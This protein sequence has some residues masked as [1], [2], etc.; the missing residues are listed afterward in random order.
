MVH[1]EMASGPRGAAGEH[2]LRLLDAPGWLAEISDEELLQ[3]PLQIVDG[4][5]VVSER[6]HS[7]GEYAD[8]SV[9]VALDDNVGLSD[10]VGPAAIAVLMGLRGGRTPADALPGLAAA[11]ESIPPDPQELVADMARALVSRGLLV[12]TEEPRT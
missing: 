8:D 1:H 12:R 3:T 2:V 11:V 9:S 5:S 4:H 7:G 10:T 6:V